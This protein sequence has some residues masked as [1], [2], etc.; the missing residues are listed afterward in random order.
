VLSV[1]IRTFWKETD[2]VLRFGT[3]AGITWQSDANSE[4]EETELKAMKL[5]SIAGGELS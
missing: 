5:L 3:G 2:N 1:A 4:W